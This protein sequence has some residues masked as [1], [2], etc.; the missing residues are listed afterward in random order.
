MDHETKY[1]QSC[2]MPLSAE[3]LYG[4]NTDGS[5]N[6]DYCVYCYK[7][8]S[9]TANCTMDEMIEFCVP[10]MA[11]YHPETTAESARA[12]MKNFFPHLKRWSK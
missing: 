12:M 6:E 11:R 5:R 4:T 1:C 2:G 8:G 7:N 10:M 3:E 9:F